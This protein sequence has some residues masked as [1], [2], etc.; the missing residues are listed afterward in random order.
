[1][2]TFG[3]MEDLTIGTDKKGLDCI[4]GSIPRKDAEPYIKQLTNVNIE[5]KV[6]RSFG[7]ANFR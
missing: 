3:Y 1:M 6:Q 2:N 5:P 4:Y 7:Y